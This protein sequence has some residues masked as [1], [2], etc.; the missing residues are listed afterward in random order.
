M[1]KIKTELILFSLGA[2]GYGL[3]EILWRGHTHWS[4]LTAGGLSFCG[5]S[6]IAE[7]FKNA[8]HFIKA[9]LGGT[10]IT[11][12]ELIFGIVF[13]LILRKNV[14]DYSK[15]PFN[16]GGQICALYSFFWVV[17]SF[18]AVPLASAVNKKISK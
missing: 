18:F 12:I 5:L 9:V 2:C 14:W 10:L 16:L 17:L 6:S 15:I 13:N 11:A 4:M 3:I 1:K 8:S 7:K